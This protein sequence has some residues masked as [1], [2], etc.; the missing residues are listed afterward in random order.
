VIPGIFMEGA[1]AQA[2]FPGGN[3][4]YTLV[5]RNGSA[6]AETNVVLC[7]NTPWNTTF[8]SLNAPGL[9]PVAPQVGTNGA[10]TCTLS[11][12]DAGESGSFTVTVN[13][14]PGTTN[15]SIVAR[16]YYIYSDVETPL[17]GPKINTVLVNPIVLSGPT[18]CD[19]GGFSFCF[20]N[21]PGVS[22]TVWRSTNLS[23]PYNQWT[24][25][26]GVVENPPGNYTFTDAATNQQC[27]YCVCSP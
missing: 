18:L 23:L 2:A 15:A 17:L 11:N 7:F 25:M 12:L 3:L 26:D 6:S 1:A 20:T 19:D 21:V 4:T 14:D 13:I 5:Y 10:V 22:F 16:D 9:A 8:Q 27:F 24:A